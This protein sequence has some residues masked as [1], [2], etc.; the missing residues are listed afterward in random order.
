MI[1]FVKYLVRADSRR[2][3]DGITLMVE[4]RGIDIHPSDFAVSHLRV[5]DG[6][7][8]SCN[9][10][11]IVGLMFAENEDQSF[12]SL[13]FEAFNLFAN[14]FFVQSPPNRGDVTTFKATV[15]TVIH[16][17]VSDVEWCKN[18]DPV[19]VHISFHLFSC[20]KNLFNKFRR[21]GKK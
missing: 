6:S 19:A 20:G 5:I 11:W 18:D 2:L 4:R 8:A 9:K 7:D 21:I 13:A 1:G 12:V 15:G 14:L 10:R 17:F 16:T 3:D